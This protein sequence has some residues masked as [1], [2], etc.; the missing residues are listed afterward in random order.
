MGS[1][2]TRPVSPIRSPT[3]PSG[4]RVCV[5]LRFSADYRTGASDWY[6]P[7]WTL[8]LVQASLCSARSAGWGDASPA[9]V[10]RT[11]EHWFAWAADH[12]EDI[13]S[14]WDLGGGDSAV[15]VVLRSQV[16]DVPAGAPA[17]LFA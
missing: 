2:C 7:R 9:V 13:V 10:Q 11:I 3:G 1:V 8:L 4:A 14:V 15:V 6:V 5:W 16:G 12:P 17:G